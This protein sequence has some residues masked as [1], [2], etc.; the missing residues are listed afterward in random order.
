MIVLIIFIEILLLVGYFVSFEFYFL[1][2]SVYFLFYLSS[3]TD[4]NEYTGFRTWNWLRRRSYGMGVEYKW[5]NKEYFEDPKSTEQRLFVVVGNTTNMGLIGGFG[6][7]SDTFYNVCYTLPHILFYIPGVRD[8]LLWSGAVSNQTDLL[9]LLKRG[10][11]VCY[12][13]SGMRHNDDD[14]VPLGPDVSMFEFAMK[15]KIHIVPV[16]VKGEDSQY[17]IS[18]GVKNYYLNRLQDW[19]YRKFGWPFPC[20]IVPKWRGRKIKLHIGVPMDSTFQESPDAFMKR[21]YSQTS[22]QLYSATAL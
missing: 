8:F 12:S 19:S 20:F 22:D 17:A 21:F 13:P 1:L 7:H 3:Y 2:S 6:V 15:H 5:A 16:R 11:S 18:T 10:W 14:E 9:V 4:G